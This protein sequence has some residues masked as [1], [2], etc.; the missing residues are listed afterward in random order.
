MKKILFALAG[1]ALLVSACGGGDEKDGDDKDKE[2][3]KENKKADDPVAPEDAGPHLEMN[4]IIADFM[5]CKETATKKHMCQH[6]IAMAICGQYGINDFEADTDAGYVKY[7]EIRDFVKNSPNWT[8]LG[9]GDDQGALDKAQ[10]YANEDVAVI[11]LSDKDYGHV[12]IIMP[13]TQEV[14][15]S[16]GGLDVPVCA[17]L[18]MI[19][20]EPFNG[21]TMAYAWGKPDDI[22][23]FARK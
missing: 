18:F 14:A 9:A 23:L 21:K 19:D 7:N 13:G 16:W 11:A 4:D 6:F 22:V 5:H 17:S 2:S 20:M 15:N 8:K 10:Q 1:M 3:K 12:V